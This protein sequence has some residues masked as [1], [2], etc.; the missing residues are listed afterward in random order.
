MS[1]SRFCFEQKNHS[2][3]LRPLVTIGLF[4]L[5]IF[6]FLHCIG[7]VSDETRQR[8]RDNLENALSFGVMHYYSLEGKYPA[9]LEELRQNYS[10]L[11]DQDF[12]YVDY[13]YMGENI[14]PD[15]TIIEEEP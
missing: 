15:I 5:L 14:Y 10:L 1:R 11:Y 8:Q 13:R 6:L 9:S 12:F 2:Q 4:V 7:S 3:A